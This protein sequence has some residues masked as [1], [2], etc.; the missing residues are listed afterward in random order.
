[1]GWPS[2]PNADGLTGQIDE[3]AVYNKVLTSTQIADHYAASGRGTASNLPPTASYTFSVNQLTA[4]FNASLSNDPDGTISSYAW[5]FGDGTTGSGV[6][7]SH[8][9]AAGG[10]H[11]V[12]LTV[13]D[14]KGATGQISRTVTTVAPPATV[15]PRAAF[16]TQILG[17]ALSVNG[18]GSSDSDGN[19][20]SYAW[21]FG[22]GTSGSG[23]TASHTYATPGPYT[24]TLT[25]TDNSGATD[26][27]SH[28]VTASNDP[29]TV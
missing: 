11:T 25:V 5:N 28:A 15:P 2:R 8:T 3:V 6:T 10:D 20:T 13:T 26:D 16:T 18:S 4:S 29:V 7:A 14:N 22:D 12:T 27:V 17:R 21:D 19:I 1:S 9:Y 23:V 24:V